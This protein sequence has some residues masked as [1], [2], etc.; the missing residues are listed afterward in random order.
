MFMYGF[1]SPSM[2][3]GR[4]VLGL[5]LFKRMEFLKFILEHIHALLRGQVVFETLIIEGAYCI[6]I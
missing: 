6:H 2:C 4:L 3:F 1:G 5:H